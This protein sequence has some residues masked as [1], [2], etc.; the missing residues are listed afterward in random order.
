MLKDCATEQELY[1]M[2]EEEYMVEE[3]ATGVDNPNDV[4]DVQ[5]LAKAGEH[6]RL[7][8]SFACV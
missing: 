5:D 3:A 7:D 1:W 6:G 8:A 4:I 2:T